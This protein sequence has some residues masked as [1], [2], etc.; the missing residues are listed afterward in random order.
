MKEER[1]VIWG[2]GYIGLTTAIAF[3]EVGRKTI[4]YDVDLNKINRINKGVNPIHNLDYWCGYC[5]NPWF[6]NQIIKSSLYKNVFWGNINFIA[7]PT[8]N[9]MEPCYDAL[10]DVLKKIINI[11]I[12]SNNRPIIIIESTLSP[13]TVDQFI[14]PMLQKKL[15]ENN[16]VLCIAP[17]RDWFISVDKTLKTLPRVYSCIG[18]ENRKTIE[19]IL[20]LI[21]DHLIYSCDYR[22][23]EAVKSI[24]N[25][26]RYVDI[27]IANQLALAFPDLD[28]EEILK[29]A[30]TKWNIDTYSPSFGIGGYCVP[31]AAEYLMNSLFKKTDLSII[32]SAIEFNNQYTEILLSAISIKKFKKIGILGLAYKNDIR[33]ADG[34]PT[35][36][37]VTAIKNRYKLEVY[38]ND[39]YYTDDEIVKLT[40]SH[41]FKF[42]QELSEFDC[43]L[44]VTAHR[45]YSF[46]GNNKI[47]DSL[48]KNA[49]IIDGTGIWEQCLKNSTKVKYIRIGRKNWYS[50]KR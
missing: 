27:S 12:T 19:K 8:Q 13:G 39:P 47:V 15:G 42:P 37:L 2:A 6:E 24:E 49:V 33:V 35:L 17:R 40:N 36:G 46:I 11:S 5:F 44:L 45:D 43:V 25:V 9:K 21:C 4:I 50:D 20:G 16:F 32:R 7:V 26:F 31:L 30:G 38:V 34:S 22:V 28:V 23:A 14:L 18:E 48:Q 29:L 1:I 3:A 41:P 10:E